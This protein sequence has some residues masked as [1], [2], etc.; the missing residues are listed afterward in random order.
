MK[1]MTFLVRLVLTIAVV[2]ALATL[3]D[4]S[5]RRSAYES[6]AIWPW[7]PLVLIGVLAVGGAWFSL[8]PIL[9]DRGRGWASKVAFA[10]L[11]FCLL[12]ALGAV[13]TV[14]F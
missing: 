1:Q 8:K 9:S 14:R 12:L 4:Y 5:V 6:I 2:I 13:V 7:L 3:L 11:V 10:A